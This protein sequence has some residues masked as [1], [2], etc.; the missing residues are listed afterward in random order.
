[1][2]CFSKI[3]FLKIEKI[4]SMSLTK[5]ITVDQKELESLALFHLL[6]DETKELCRSKVGTH[7]IGDLIT[8][9]F[10]SVFFV[11]RDALFR[12]EKF[13]VWEDVPSEWLFVAQFLEV[14]NNRDFMFFSHFWRTREHP[15]PEGEDLQFLKS[16]LADLT[17]PAK[18][19]WIDFCCLPQRQETKEETRYADVMLSKIPY[20][21]QNCC[22]IWFYVKND[23]RN[24]AWIFYEVFLTVLLI[25]LPQI[26][27]LDP[28]Y[29]NLITEFLNTGESVSAFIN[30]NN[31]NTSSQGDLTY[32]CNSLTAIL[33]LRSFQYPISWTRQIIAQMTVIILSSP[34]GNIPRGTV[35][36]V[37]SGITVCFD[38]GEV[39][40]KN[41]MVEID[42]K[43]IFSKLFCNP[44]PSELV[45]SHLKL[46]EISMLVASNEEA[47][48]LRISTEITY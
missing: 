20:L 26:H 16:A 24:R 14:I 30:R 33:K 32:I 31:L 13:V 23:N 36:E 19:I 15:D 45:N 27:D 28:K 17:E 39:L 46:N 11:R 8:N 18:Y 21:L 43:L 40:L 37:I 1:M 5:T 34:P 3:L 35:C 29:V 12:M 47:E 4:N 22:F 2:I 6:E 41:Q 44:V 7:R 38:N 10:C 25:H 9:N 48:L 42:H